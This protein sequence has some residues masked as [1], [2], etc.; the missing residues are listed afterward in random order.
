MLSHIFVFMYPSI[1]I[2]VHDV[3]LGRVFGRFKSWGKITRNW[4]DFLVTDP[5]SFLSCEVTVRKLNFQP[6]GLR[7][8]GTRGSYSCAIEACID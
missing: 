1:E 2:F 4:T 8:N 7:E 3:L 5:S 6:P